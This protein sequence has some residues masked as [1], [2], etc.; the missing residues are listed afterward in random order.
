MVIS[1]KKLMGIATQ[2]LLI[3]GIVVL[4]I[5]CFRTDAMAQEVLNVGRG[6]RSLALGNTGVASATDSAALYYN[7]AILGN[8]EG[9]WFDYG[10]WTVEGSQ[11]FTEIEAGLGLAS[12]NF[13]YV[14]REGITEDMKETFLSKE[15][16]YLR[17]NAGMN[18]FINFA[19]QGFTVAGSY[20][21]EA[22]YTTTVVDGATN[23]YQ[24]DDVVQKVGLS[25][26]IGMGQLVIGVTGNRIERRVAQDATTDTI[27]N[28][29]DRYV[30]TGYDVGILYRMATV[31]HVTWGVAV[32]NYGG[33]KFG[34]S[35]I[36]EP[37]QIALGM[38]IN[39]DLG[40][41]R[42]FPAIDVRQ[43]NAESGKVNTVHAGLEV[44]IFP[45]S[46]GGNYLT[47]RVGY[48]QGNS[49]QGVELN[50]FNRNFVFGVTQYGEEVG[51]GEE[52]VEN[53]RTIA[54]MSF[55]F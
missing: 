41:I 20:L 48:N 13:P 35:D 11:G 45:N 42:L 49:T 32:L 23:I 2:V 40:L 44:G 46:T 37:Q 36:E 54:F 47:Y 53:R 17:A 19:R 25:I 3:L 27:P 38:S 28:W 30:G 6:Y 51:Q 4:Q 18:L 8:V 31:L 14:N 52:K 26:P 9:W 7:P 1:M 22:V 29:S 15:N 50:F 5:F 12:I 39:H 34:D 33:I 24:R 21:Q 55:G 10:A 16:P 43:I